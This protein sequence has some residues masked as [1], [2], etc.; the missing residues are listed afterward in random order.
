[1]GVQLNIKSAEARQLAEKVAS[2]TGVSITEAVTDAL[3]RRLKEVERE[4]ATADDALAQR[5]AEFRA[6]IAGSREC[7]PD[8]ML[9]V[10]HGDLLYGED[11]LP[12]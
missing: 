1:M 2:T 7:W 4:V 5:V 8:A 10:D 3:R 12:R 6:M 11:G 9:D